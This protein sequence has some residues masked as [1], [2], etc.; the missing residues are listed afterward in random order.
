MLSSNGLI[1]PR[2][3]VVKNNVT[4]I[5]SFNI[6]GSVNKATT[7]WENGDIVYRVGAGSPAFWI[8]NGSSWLAK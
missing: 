6:S 4:V 5:K 8:F 1:K 7:N 2:R 3:E